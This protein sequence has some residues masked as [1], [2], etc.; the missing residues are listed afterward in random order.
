MANPEF[1]DSEANVRDVAWAEEFFGTQDV[2][3]PRTYPLFK[4]TELHYAQGGERTLEIKVLDGEGCPM[5]GVEVAIGPRT[6][7]G[8]VAHATT[9]GDGCAYVPMDKAHRYYVPGQGH[10]ACAVLQDHSD[11]YNSAGWVAG[12]KRWLNPVFMYRPEPPEPPEPPPEPPEPPE[13]PPEPPE[14]PEPPP[15][16][17][18]PPEPLPPDKLDRIIELLEQIVERLEGPGE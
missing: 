9:G 6:V 5:P 3:E 7:A 4:L 17:P 13:P 16:P 18:E 10:Y 11:V 12:Q 14:P 8:E 1:Y 15:E 2:H